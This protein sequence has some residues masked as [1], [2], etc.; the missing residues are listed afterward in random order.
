VEL[1]FPIRRDWRGE[2]VPDTE[3]CALHASMNEARLV[4]QVR[5]PFHGDPPPAGPAGRFA[6]LWEHEVVELFLLGE[7]ERY[8]E[9][10]LGPHGHYLALA[11]DGARRVVDDRIEVE[12]ETRIEGRLW[13][14]RAELPRAHLPHPITRAN[15]YAIHGA[16]RGRRHLA[17]HPVP[18]ETPDFHRLACFP[19]IDDFARP[20]R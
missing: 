10:E 14:A 6:R 7:G 3:H 13:S 1:F 5:A 16:G 19:A 15:A 12:L 2:P 4:V 17:A 8:T 20:S 18:G 9:V 11:L